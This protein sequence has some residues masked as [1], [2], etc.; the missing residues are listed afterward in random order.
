MYLST[1]RAFGDFN[2]DRDDDHACNHGLTRT[3]SGRGQR[4]HG[5]IILI[6]WR[7]VCACVYSKSHYPFRTSA[8]RIVVH[9]LVLYTLVRVG[10][11]LDLQ[12]A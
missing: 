2:D 1:V 7:S 5:V 11:A 3:A 9:P 12:C 4:L 8:V 6:C 10:A